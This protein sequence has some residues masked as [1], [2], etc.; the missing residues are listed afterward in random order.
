MSPPGYSIYLLSPLGIHTYLR[1]IDKGKL[2]WASSSGQGSPRPSRTA[3]SKQPGM[4]VQL[5]KDATLTQMTA[6]SF[7][8][9]EYDT[10]PLVPTPGDFKFLLRKG[11]PE[12]LN[13]TVWMQ[14]FS[15]SRVGK[16]M[17][18]SWSC[19]NI[20]RKLKYKISGSHIKLQCECLKFSRTMTNLI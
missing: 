4:L 12:L 14:V 7:A 10:C 13:K 15:C 17:G 19:I 11:R 18:F 8:E 20:S 2:L 6:Y 1:G 9:T 3:Q 16:P 5:C